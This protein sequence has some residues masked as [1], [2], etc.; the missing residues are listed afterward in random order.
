MREPTIYR[1]FLLPSTLEFDIAVTRA[2]HF[3]PRGPRFKVVF[4]E[5]GAAKEPAPAPIEETIGMG[6]LMALDTR[7]A[8]ER[9]RRWQALLFL[10]ML[11]DQALGIACIR[12]GE[13]SDYA[14]GTDRL[15][16]GVTESYEQTLARS[17][18]VDELLR[19]LALATKELLLEVERVKPELAGALDETLREI[20]DSR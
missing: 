14:R 10:N 4:G 13:P 5:S 11:R 20:T 15:P 18:N 6:W 16:R 2:A 12:H 3:A 8:I 19:A 1:V 7:M 17:L 9:G